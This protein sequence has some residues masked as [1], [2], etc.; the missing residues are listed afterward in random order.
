MGSEAGPGGACG[1]AG[2]LKLTGSQVRKLRV[3]SPQSPATA[4]YSLTM[5]D[6]HFDPVY[7][8]RHYLVLFV[9]VVPG[10][11]GLAVCA[12]LGL[13][14]QAVIVS[15]VLTLGLP[16]VLRASHVKRVVFGENLIVVRQLFRDRYF[17]YTEFT[18]VEPHRVFTKRGI[19]R[20]GGW[21]NRESFLDVLRAMR[22]RGVLDNTEFARD[23]LTGPRETDPNH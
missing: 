8:A 1:R 23:V 14:R 6:L 9:G 20:I 2:V 16:M 5:E 13:G 15:I 7:P 21:V 3:P 18:R 12:T 11:I 17:N 22:D 10:L 19:L 4:L